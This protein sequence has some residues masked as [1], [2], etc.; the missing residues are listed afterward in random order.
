MQK[1]FKRM[2]IS[3]LAMAAIIPSALLAGCG[4]GGGSNNNSNTGPSTQ[5]R[6]VTGQASP[7]EGFIEFKSTSTCKNN[8]YYLTISF[9]EEATG[10]LTGKIVGRKVGPSNPPPSGPDKYKGSL[11][12]NITGKR[13]GDQITFTITGDIK[14]TYTGKLTK[15]SGFTKISGDFDDQPGC[16]DGNGNL[17]GGELFVVGD[18]VP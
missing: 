12:G 7:F 10:E 6:G 9:D 18:P 13:E 2:T 16:S 14:G 15:G 11:K 3:A 4:G 8:G 17:H 5:G 1:N